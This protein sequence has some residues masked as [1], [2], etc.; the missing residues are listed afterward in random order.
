[1]ESIE[2]L[3]GSLGRLVLARGSV[4]RPGDLTRQLCRE[5]RQAV[6]EGVAAGPAGRGVGQLSAQVGTAVEGHQ[7][8]RLHRVRLLTLAQDADREHGGHEH[9]DGADHGDQ[10]QDKGAGAPGR[11]A[12]QGARDGGQVERGQE[13]ADDPHGAGG[14]TIPSTTCTAECSGQ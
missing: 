6:R 2:R 5:R 8:R 11:D 9:E 3:M 13:D 7:G 4:Q 1:M 14:G 10:D 12:L